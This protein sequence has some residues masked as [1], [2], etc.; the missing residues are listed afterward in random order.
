MTILCDNFS[1][2][3]PPLAHGCDD[4]EVLWTD[5]CLKCHDQQPGA[6]GCDKQKYFVLLTNLWTK[7]ISY[8]YYK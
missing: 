3:S 6:Y 7:I 4:F 8:V 1:G 2:T 5:V